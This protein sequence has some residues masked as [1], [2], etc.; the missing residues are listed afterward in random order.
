MKKLLLGLSI[1]FVFVACGKE[2]ETKENI[3]IKESYV[4]GTN[5]EYPPFEYLDNNKIS[6]LDPDIIEEAFKRM[7]IKVTWVNT[8]FDGLI[9]ALQ[10]KKVDL[11]IA[12]MSITDERLKA[13]NFSTPYLVSKVVFLGNKNNPINTMEELEGKTFGAELGTTKEISARKIKDSKVVPFAGTTPA[14]LALKAQKVDVIVVDESVAE[15]YLA[16]NDDLTLIGYHEGEPKAIAFNKDDVEFL[17]KF[18]KTLEGML[19]DGTINNLRKK[20]GV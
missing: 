10:T 19:E 17:E 14:L 3:A 12:G 4:V 6:G 16:N 8:T 1:L 13:V 2:K 11:V 20:Y 18:N 7:D 15:N 5:A 9:P